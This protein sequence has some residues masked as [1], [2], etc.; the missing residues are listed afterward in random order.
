MLLLLVREVGGAVRADA[1]RAA[2]HL[3]VGDRGAAGGGAPLPEPILFR[4]LT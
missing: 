3:A 4:R 2:V 1:P